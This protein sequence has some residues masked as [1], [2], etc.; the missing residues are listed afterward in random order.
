MSKI[1]FKYVTLMLLLLLCVAISAGL[2]NTPPGSFSKATIAPANPADRAETELLK[3]EYGVG[4]SEANK[5][6]LIIN[7]AI[8]K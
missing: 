6:T 7:R 1:C 5:S 2:I 3:N 8:N 4:G